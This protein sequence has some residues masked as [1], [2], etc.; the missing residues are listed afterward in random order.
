MIRVNLEEEPEIVKPTAQKYHLD[1]GLPL[2]TG[3]SI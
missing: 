2:I 3:N 1:F